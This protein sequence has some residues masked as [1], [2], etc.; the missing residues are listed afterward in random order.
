MQEKE[1]RPNTHLRRERELKGWSQR[2]LAERLGT[3]E[4]V[5][6]RWES[7]LHKPNRHFQT[8]LCQLFGKRADELGFMD[9]PLVLKKAIETAREPEEATQQSGTQDM[10]LPRRDFLQTLG[11]LGTGLFIAQQIQEN[12]PLVESYSS[13]FSKASVTNLATITQQFRAMQ[14]RGDTFI[15]DGVNTHIKTIQEA[16]EHTAD[17]DIRRELWRVLAQTQIVAGFNPMKKTALGRAK[18]LLEVAIASA[19]NSG[20][21]LLAGAALGHLAHFSL[22][23]EQNLTKAAQLLSRAQEYVQTSHPLNGWFALVMA[24]LA[25]KAGQEQHCEAYLTEAMTIA[26]HLPQT[27]EYTDIYFTDFSLVSVYIFAV[28]CWLVIG[29]VVKAYTY[30]TEINLEELSDNRRASAF[31]DA[32]RACAMLGEFDMAQNFAFQAIDK[33]LSTQQLY[34]IP[35]CMTLAQ[36]IQK[37]EPDKPYAPAIAD[38]ARL[39]LQQN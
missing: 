16:L 33:A 8:Q 19:Q 5:V 18:T 31:Y 30:L 35:R 20:D 25:A 34:V 27:P 9:K 1:K 38:Y 32:S 24:S 23:E 15:T 2:T 6:N 7:G 13:D 11:V 22:R 29:N 14:R 4:H 21:A 37:K 17:D 28:N 26:H 3:T 36:T 12:Y 39:A 10:N